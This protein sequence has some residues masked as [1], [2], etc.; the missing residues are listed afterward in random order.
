MT[1]EEQQMGVLRKLQLQVNKKY[2]VNK[3]TL[4][5]RYSEQVCQTL[6]VQ[7]IKWN[8]LSKFSKWELGFVHYIKVCYV[9][10]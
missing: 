9:E 7:Y 8:M 3:Y 1:P 4:K 6:F 10:V 5:P 2:I